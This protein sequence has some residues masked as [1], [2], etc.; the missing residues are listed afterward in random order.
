MSHN[1]DCL[2]AHVFFQEG[3]K[4][5]A[6]QEDRIWRKL[7][8]AVKE[9]QKM[10]SVAHTRQTQA[11]VYEAQGGKNTSKH[12]HETEPQAYKALVQQWSETKMKQSGATIG[13]VVSW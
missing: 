10:E 4:K 6:H 3:S 9:S 13:L 5:Q 2:V 11:K 8:A 7:T 1:A 12:I